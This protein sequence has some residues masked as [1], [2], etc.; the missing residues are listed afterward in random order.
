MT[1]KA[2]VINECVECG[3]EF[4]TLLPAEHFCS[5]TCESNFYDAQAVLRHCPDCGGECLGHTPIEQL[6][7]PPVSTWERV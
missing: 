3:H 2:R 5:P 4:T 7:L 1:A 6:D